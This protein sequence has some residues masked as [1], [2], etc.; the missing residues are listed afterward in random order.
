MAY[1]KNEW[2]QYINLSSDM[3]SDTTKEI[4]KDEVINVNSYLNEDGSYKFTIYPWYLF[5]DAYEDIL[6]RAG[7]DK[8]EKNEVILSQSK[9][10][11]KSKY[12]KMIKLAN[13]KVGD[14][15]VINGEEFKIAGITDSFSPYLDQYG[16]EDFNQ[17]TKMSMVLMPSKEYISKED[18]M[19]ISIDL[20]LSTDKAYEIDNLINEINKINEKVGTNLSGK[21]LYS[22][23]ISKISEQMIVKIVLYTLVV[24]I[25][26]FSIANIFNTISSSVML[27]KGEFAMLK[28][29]GLSE[30]QMNKI[31]ALEGFFYGV[32]SI[33]YG[34]VISIVILY[35]IY[36]FMIDT[37]LYVFS[38]PWINIIIGIGMV[39]AVIF[40]AMIKLKIRLKKE[41]II[42]SIRGK[43]T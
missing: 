40:M 8:L 39:Y 18:M 17:P 15:I 19:N 41:N 1:V 38:I 6:K 14:T 42:D 24:L 25:S 10:L 11:Q 4:I 16:Y 12:G 33:C 26:V 21:N 13:Y 2:L 37:K 36:L 28:S 7:I 23:R 3:L 32:D 30:R 20:H 34:G 9:Y 43:E 27:N 35:L 5:G 29:V 22:N 31:L